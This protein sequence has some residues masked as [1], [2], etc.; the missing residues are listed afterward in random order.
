MQN[1]C[2]P[3]H[4]SN[5]IIICIRDCLSF[6]LEQA[7]LPYSIIAHQNSADMRLLF[8]TESLLSPLGAGVAPARGLDACMSFQVATKGC[9]CRRLAEG[10]SLCTNVWFGWETGVG[11]VLR[12]QRGRK[13]SGALMCVQLRVHPSFHLFLDVCV[14]G[15]AMIRLKASRIDHFLRP[16]DKSEARTHAI[17]ARSHTRQRLHA[18]D[19]ICARS[20]TD[21]YFNFNDPSCLS[22]MSRFQFPKTPQVFNLQLSDTSQIYHVQHSSISAMCTNVW[23]NNSSK[24][25]SSTA[26]ESILGVNHICDASTHSALWIWSLALKLPCMRIE[27]TRK[28]RNNRWWTYEQEC[29]LPN[30]IESGYTGVIAFE[31]HCDMKFMSAALRSH[32]LHSIKKERCENKSQRPTWSLLKQSAQKS[33]HSA[34]SVSGIAGGSFDFATCHTAMKH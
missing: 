31:R 25:V 6:H 16:M 10:R 20:Q 33:L 28:V 14:R 15:Q 24:K 3:G 7:H 12:L 2:V 8:A 1:Q 11:G 19:R 30:L 9:R 5:V 13:R 29:N 27:C 32:S 23:I 21:T 4:Y 34:E 18:Q 26:L 17:S 22:A